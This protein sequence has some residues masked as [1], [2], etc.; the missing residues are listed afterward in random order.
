MHYVSK[1]GLYIKYD[2]FFDWIVFWY[3]ALGLEI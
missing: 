3:D 1:E 2:Y